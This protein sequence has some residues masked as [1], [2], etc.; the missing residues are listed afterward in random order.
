MYSL[1]P[2][3]FSFITDCLNEWVVAKQEYL[4][5]EACKVKD[6][7]HQKVKEMITLAIYTTHFQK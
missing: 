5:S 3:L 1:F 4:Y 6:V 2:L 7:V